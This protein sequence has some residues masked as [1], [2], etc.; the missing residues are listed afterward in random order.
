[1]SHYLLVC[2]FLYL[3]HMQHQTVP[4]GIDLTVNILTMGYWP[5][6]SPMEVLIPSDVSSSLCLTVSFS[7]EHSFWCHLLTPSHISVSVALLLQLWIKILSE[8]NI[9]LARFISLTFLEVN[10][11][12]RWFS[13]QHHR[14]QNR[15]IIILYVVVFWPHPHDMQS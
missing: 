14:L 15:I 10:K 13:V 12:L 7:S 6:Y 5:T 8:S 2:Q 9:F 4:G 11:Q 3:Q 1:M